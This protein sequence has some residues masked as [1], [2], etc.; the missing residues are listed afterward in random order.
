MERATIAPAWHTLRSGGRLLALLTLVACEQGVPIP[1]P[2][3]GETALARAT[4]TTAATGDTAP[5]TPTADTAPPVPTGDTAPPYDPECAGEGAG[6]L[7]IGHGGRPAFQAYATDDTVPIVQGAGGGPWGVD[8]DLLTTGLDTRDPVNMVLRM[9]TAMGDSVNIGQLVLQCNVP[10]P[11]WVRV[12]AQFDAGDQAAVGGGALDGA[13]ATLSATL[14][15]IGIDLAQ[16][17]VDIVLT[18][19]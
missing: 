11:G 3:T 4:G 10:G 5:P 2:A 9:E 7:E 13:D 1:D 19:P 12:H 17:S 14:T 8:L 16:D 18:G 6:T 15:D